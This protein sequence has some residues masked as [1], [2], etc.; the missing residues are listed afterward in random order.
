MHFLK[1]CINSGILARRIGMRNGFALE[2]SMSLPRPKCGQVDPRA[3]IS[4]MVSGV[5]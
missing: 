3:L 2:A 5:C 4:E 1:I